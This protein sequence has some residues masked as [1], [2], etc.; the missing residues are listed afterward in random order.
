M[1]VDVKTEQRKFWKIFDE[2]LIENGEPFSILHEKSGEI[3][4][5]GVINKVHS[6][7]DNA[8]S[9]DFLVR[10]QKVRL[11]IYVRDDLA[12]CNVLEKHRTEIESAVSVPLHWIKGIKNLNTRRI[13]YFVPVKVGDDSQYDEVI[14]DILPIIIEM[15]KICETYA[16]FDF[17]DF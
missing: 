8:L 6:F 2:K 5:Y 12:L 15:K 4:Y 11:N 14:D 1:K 17:F 7:V 10:E 16:R 13:A 3:T 9:V